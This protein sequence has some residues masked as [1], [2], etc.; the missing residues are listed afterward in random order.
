MSSVQIIR[1]GPLGFL[2]SG[3]G[4]SQLRLAIIGGLV[5]VMTLTPYF[6]YDV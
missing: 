3:P 1:T 2:Q 5:I 6:G 4:L